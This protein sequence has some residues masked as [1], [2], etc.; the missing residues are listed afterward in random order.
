MLVTSPDCPGACARTQQGGTTLCEGLGLWGQA[1][2]FQLCNLKLS[3]LGFPVCDQEPRAGVRIKCRDTPQG[4]SMAGGNDGFRLRPP[5]ASPGWAEPTGCPCLDAPSPGA[6]QLLGQVKLFHFPTP[7]AS[8]S[9]RV[10]KHK[11]TKA[12]DR[13]QQVTV[14]LSN[15]APCPQHPTA[16]WPAEGPAA[17]LSQTVPL[18]QEPQGHTRP[19]AQASRKEGSRRKALGAKA[20]RRGLRPGVGKHLRP[21]FGAASGAQRGAKNPRACV[22]PTASCTRQGL[23]NTRVPWTLGG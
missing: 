23:G 21:L 12:T 17:C 19:S 4:L 20:H 16:H 2:G 5:P 15:G 10:M 7:K 6:T 18:A 3:G 9:H 13:R 1:S 22:H 11:P 8:L 14:P